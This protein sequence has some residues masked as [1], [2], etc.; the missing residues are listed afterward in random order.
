MKTREITVIS[1]MPMVLLAASTGYSDT[2]VYQNNFENGAGSAWSS[3]AIAF[4]PGGRSFLGRFG[5]FE[6]CMLFGSPVRLDLHNLPAH[7][8]IQL[9]FDLFIMDS[10]DGNGDGTYHAGPDIWM[11]MEGNQNMLIRTTFTTMGGFGYHQSYP[12]TYEGGFTYDSP[13][14]N[15]HANPPNAGAIEVNTLG[16][17]GMSAVYH[18]DVAFNHTSDDLQLSFL[19]DGHGCQEVGDESWGLDNVVVTS[20]LGSGP[21][22]PI[23][24][25]PSLGVLLVFLPLLFAATPTSSSSSTCT[26]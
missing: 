26:C 1:I 14:A 15:K 12:N 3:A 20:F 7:N 23:P 8:A 22:N 13:D 19:T 24:E 17:F 18:L 10:W 5:T 16:G 25:A 6:T 2:L 9:N 21:P 11:L 4:T